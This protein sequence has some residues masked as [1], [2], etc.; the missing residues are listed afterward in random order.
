MDNKSEQQTESNSKSEEIR[1]R[2]IFEHGIEQAKQ[3]HAKYIE[4]Y[5]KIGY[6]I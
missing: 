3:A 6:S 2:V 1:Q 4:V 5:R